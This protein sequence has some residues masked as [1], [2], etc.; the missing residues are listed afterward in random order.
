MLSDHTGFKLEIR[1]RRK[2]ERFTNIW[3]LNNTHL[4]NQWIK[5]ESTKRMLKHLNMN[6]NKAT[7]YQNVFEEILKK[8]FTVVFFFLSAM[9]TLQES[10][11]I[12][13]K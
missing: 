4:N 9:Y 13:N 11:N 3:K 8:V 1:N 10:N 6:E 2:F 12:S 5:E 7:I